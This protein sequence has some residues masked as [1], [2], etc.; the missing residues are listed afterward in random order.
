MQSLLGVRGAGERSQRKNG[1]RCSVAGSKDGGGK[2]ML[3][4]R[5]LGIGKGTEMNFPLKPPEKDAA[6]LTPR[7]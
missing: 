7:F 1:Q 4:G 3:K 6:L 2:T 5:L